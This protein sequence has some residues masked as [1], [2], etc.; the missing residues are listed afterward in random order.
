VVR[1]GLIVGRV[2]VVRVGKL[3]CPFLRVRT[4]FEQPDASKY[5]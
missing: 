1:V 4:S 5:R 3:E 2:R